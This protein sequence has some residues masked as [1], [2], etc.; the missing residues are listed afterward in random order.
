MLK[1]YTALYFLLPLFLLAFSVK[2]G[3]SQTITIEQSQISVKEVLQEITAQTGQNFSY[4]SQAIDT[5]QQ[6]SFFI[7]D[8]S[9]EETLDQLA[10]QIPITYS[11][12]EGQIVLNYQA[13]QSEPEFF[14][15]SGFLT[16]KASG[17]TLP[18]ASVFAR[19]V[20]RG[21]STNAFGFYSLRLPK[22][23]YDVEY[24]YVGFDTEKVNLNLDKDAKKDMTLGYISIDL[25]NVIVK[26][27]ISDLLDKKQLSV[28]EMDPSDLGNMP[29][30]AGESGLIK[31]LETLPG[32]KT[33]SDGSAFFFTRGG[34]KDQNLI[35]IDDAPIYNPA[36]LFGFYSMVIPDFTKSVNVYKSDIPVNLGDRLSSIIDIRTKDGNLNHFEVNGA[37]N[38]L[39]YRF[40][41]E[42]PVVK[43]KSSFFV[44]F[45][46]SSFGWIY[47]RAAPEVDVRFNDFSV[48][49]N[50]R[51]NEKSRLFFTVFR[52][53]DVFG[54]TNLES[55]ISWGNFAAT[56]RWNHIINPKLFSNT[57]LYTG[58]YQYELFSGNNKWHSGIAKLSLKSDFTYYPTPKLT[59]RFGAELHGYYFNPGQ[60]ITD[61]E[62]FPF[63]PS[64]EEDYSRQ[65]VLYFN[66]DYELL[67]NWRL[68][69]GVRMPV[70]ENLGPSTYYTFDENYQ[71]LDSL[72]VEQGVYQRYW[73]V[74]P[75][76]SLSHH[77]DSTAS[78]KL[79]YGLYHQY[80]QLI[81]NSAS[82][83]TSME[84]WLPSS[85]TIKPQQA[86]QYTLGY[87]KYF[88][89]A[90]IDVRA[91]AYYKKMKNQ[92]D[93]EPHANILVN[94]LLEGELRFGDTRSYGLE[95]FIK[96]DFGKLNGWLAYTY[97]RTLRQTRGVNGGREY[98][99][100]Y[101]RPHDFSV[102]LNYQVNPR[103]LLSAYWTAYTGSAFSSPSGF[104]TF[105][106][107]T[108]PIYSEKNNDRLPNYN[109]LDL[110]LKYN[111]NK[112]PDSKYQHSL[113][114]SIYNALAHKN[115]VAVNFNKILDEEDKPIVQADF[116]QSK[117]VVSTQADLI[118]FFPSLTY[119]FGLNLKKEP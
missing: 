71:L 111:F 115:V 68:K 38:P 48:K 65:S 103:L 33:H 26:T 53:T 117:N 44:S 12:V 29:E 88:E 94:P 42:G 28:M 77:L 27:P 86:Q 89:K 82:P 23:L 13:K 21:T 59:G 39:L 47:N 64:L 19:A 74:D 67:D 32:I 62:S 100:F 96:K 80:L 83:F 6:I 79:S 102:L 60:V 51:F 31:G 105:N 97:S 75:R 50:Y 81:S 25:P 8:A 1:T 57:I 104:Y 46:Q 41:V 99:A 93:Y 112:N 85:P 2:D 10:S 78:L 4:N 37:I 90:K 95:L 9:L 30:F 58:N 63:F 52:G 3:K 49:W 18:G 35:I 113:T 54:N 92:I 56:L 70:W 84:V 109:R 69:A 5:D 119:K 106:Q 66:T 34:D 22:G 55:G 36:H 40:S 72:S 7:K 11:L 110:A 24:S 98:P 45:R 101:D 43:E 118:R 20:S 116:I 17:E 91:E 61:E 87:L 107:Q 108:V 16:D 15:I 76:L 14:T 73:N 114:F